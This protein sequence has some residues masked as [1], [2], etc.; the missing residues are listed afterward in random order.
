[1]HAAP[2]GTRRLIFV[3]GLHRS[4][5]SLLATLL[6]SHTEASGLTRT[7]VN[8]DEG[9]FLQ[10]AYPRDAELGGVGQFAFDGRARAAAFDDP[11][12]AAQTRARL[13]ESWGRHWDLS[14]TFLVEKTPGNALNAS[15]L[16]SVFGDECAFVM[17]TRHPIANAMATRKWSR[18]SLFALIEHWMHAQDSM[19]AGLPG[20]RRVAWISYEGLVGDPSG[21]LARLQAFL[22]MP[23]QTVQIGRVRN[24]NPRYFEEWAAKYAGRVEAP[25]PAMV[26]GDIP[27]ARFGT[28][29]VWR[30]RK[31]LRR[32]LLRTGVDV[33]STGREAAA[34][35]ARYEERANT[36]GYSML[37]L[38]RRPRT[39]SLAR[40]GL[41]T[42]FDGPLERQ[43]GRRS[44]DV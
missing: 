22:G 7:G 21:T 39:E 32:T 11:Q 33:L 14:K 20:L 37:D 13:L 26:R 10:N 9:Q 41:L 34:I 17:I 43:Y 18:T 6:A 30:I 8:E 24:M 16:Q 28:R 27:H 2:L 1:M 40:P 44:T 42:S 3:G 35:V 23:A 5:T 4:G 15:F 19:R 25:A 12:A 36:Y 29:T 31:S 38:T